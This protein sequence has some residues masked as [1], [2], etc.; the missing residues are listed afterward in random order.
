ML[1]CSL[2]LYATDTIRLHLQSYEEDFPQ[3]AD[4]KWIHTYNGEYPALQFD[5]F[6]FSHMLYTPFGSTSEMTYW[7]GFTY[8]TS[9]DDADYGKYGT[10][11]TWPKHQWG[12]MAGGGIDSTGKVVKGAPYLVAYWGGDVYE[13]EHEHSL[14]VVFSDG[15]TRRPLGIWV[16][17]HPWPYYGIIHGD[18]FASPFASNGDFFRLTVHAMD[19][20]GQE[21]SRPASIHLAQFRGDTLDQSRSW[22]WLD[23][24]SF[25]QVAGFWFTMQSS[26]STKAMGMNTS[27]HFCFGGLEV[28]EHVDEIPRPSGL[29]A[30]PIDEHSIR[31][32]WTRIQEAEYYRVYLDSTLVDSTR[33]ASYTFHGMKTYTV[34]T[35]YVQAVS[36]YGESSEWGYSSSRTLDMTPPAAPKNLSAEP[37]DDD[38]MQITWDAAVDNVGVKYYIIYVDGVRHSLSKR[39][40]ATISGL[41]PATTYTIEVE[42]V[43]TSDNHSER[44]SLQVTAG[45]ATALTCP[46]QDASAVIY[47]MHGHSYP[48]TATPTSGVYIIRTQNTTHIQLR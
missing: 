7:D 30:E 33:T 38:Q 36:A 41:S 47:D 22:Q 31:L 26:D 3:D 24:S 34:Y 39:T 15:I 18:G 12:C 17:N 46:E 11:D 44:A 23:L 10:S 43:D 28:L 48:R 16:C 9:G 20:S 8:C 5:I 37:M 32:T 45:V 6:D 35:M 42:A 1:L 25:G 27:A 14:Q 29:K 40:C 2:S 19:E 13:R 21:T 4:G